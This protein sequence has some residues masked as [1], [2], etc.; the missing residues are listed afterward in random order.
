MRMVPC[1]FE[2]VVTIARDRHS[3]CIDGMGEDL[4][5]AARDR[6]CLVKQDHIVTMS[7]KSI[8]DRAWNVVIEKKPHAS[9]ALV[10]GKASD[11][12]SARW[13]S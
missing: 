6:Q 10:C 11:S 3:L 2:E 5:V 7:K 12:I 13:S 9:G 1:Q 8:G 4:L